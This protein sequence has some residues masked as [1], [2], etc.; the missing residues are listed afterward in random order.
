MPQNPQC[1]PGQLHRIGWRHTGQLAVLRN[2]GQETDNSLDQVDTEQITRAARGIHGHRP[3]GLQQV[4]QAQ[5]Q[6]LRA[7]QVR[8]CSTQV[9][10]NAADSALV[11]SLL[12]TIPEDR[13][14]LHSPRNIHLHDLVVAAEQ[15]LCQPRQSRG[16]GNLAGEFLGHLRVADWHQR[17]PTDQKCEATNDLSGIPTDRDALVRQEVRCSSNYI[18]CDGLALVLLVGAQVTDS[19]Q[20]LAELVRC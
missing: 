12:A 15:Q 6:R 11:N 18:C 13:H 17:S 9:L 4:Q 5:R 7:R 3:Q 10:C 14:C 1:L 19:P 8:Q 2:L 16:S 20:G